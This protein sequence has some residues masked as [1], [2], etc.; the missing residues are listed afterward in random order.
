MTQREAVHDIID[1]LPDDLLG[2][3][4]EYLGRIRRERFAALLAA[5]PYDDEPLS[6]ADLVGIAEAEADVA[7]GRVVRDRD[8]DAVLE[9]MLLARR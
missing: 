1:C 4:G 5:A 8:L 2:Q 6:E 3:V 9:A 7:A